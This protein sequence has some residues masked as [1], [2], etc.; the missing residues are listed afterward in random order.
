MLERFKPVFVLCFP[1][2]LFL[3]YVD[4]LKANRDGNGILIEAQQS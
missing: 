1:L 3:G 2:I 4:S